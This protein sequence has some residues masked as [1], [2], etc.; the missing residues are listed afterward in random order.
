MMFGGECSAIWFAAPI[1]CC[2]GLCLAY[3]LHLLIDR[4]L[5]AHFASVLELPK[6]SLEGRIDWLDLQ[7]IGQ[8]W[9]RPK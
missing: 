3:A 4:L 9:Q 7:M 1:L 5:L 6:N 8:R 2:Y